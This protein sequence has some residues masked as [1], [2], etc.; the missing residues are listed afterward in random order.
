[1]VEKLNSDLKQPWYLMLF[2]NVSFCKKLRCNKAPRAR[3][4]SDTRYEIKP[5]Q[6]R[7]QST[8]TRLI[9]H[10]RLLEHLRN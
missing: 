9:T 2:F 10:H 8:I 5:Q 1:M 6:K 3:I 4:S 7:N